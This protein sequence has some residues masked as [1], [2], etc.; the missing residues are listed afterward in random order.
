MLKYT[1]LIVL[2]KTSISHYH[3]PAFIFPNILNLKPVKT[4]YS[5]G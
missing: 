1:G 2:S 3:L 4:K 5:I